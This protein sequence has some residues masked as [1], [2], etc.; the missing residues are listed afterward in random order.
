[1][2]HGLSDREN[3]AVR[4]NV[5]SASIIHT[6]GVSNERGVKSSGGP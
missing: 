1:M 6:Q 2:I 4:Y 3:S 5:G